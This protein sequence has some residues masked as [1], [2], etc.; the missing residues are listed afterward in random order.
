MTTKTRRCLLHPCHVSSLLCFSRCK[1]RTL[2]NCSPAEICPAERQPCC[3][4]PLLSLSCRA[5]ALQQVSPA[6]PQPSCTSAQAQS[7]LY[8]ASRLLYLSPGT[9]S[10]CHCRS[11]PFPCQSC[12][13]YPKGASPSLPTA[14]AGLRLGDLSLASGRSVTNWVKGNFC[15]TG[16]PLCNVHLCS[17]RQHV[18]CR[19]GEWLRAATTVYPTATWG[20][21]PKPQR[22]CSS[23]EGIRQRPAAQTI[24]WVSIR[25]TTLRDEFSSRDRLH[26]PFPWVEMMLHS[27]VILVTSQT[28]TSQ[29][30]HCFATCRLRDRLLL[31]RFICICW[32]SDW[33]VRRTTHHCPG[34]PPDHI[35]EIVSGG[36]AGHFRLIWA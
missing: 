22:T 12:H 18:V 30:G 35:A 31:V 34:G 9:P 23:N 15:W 10:C 4:S 26:N 1:T 16:L 27:L 5:S 29:T 3:T 7:Q 8:Y 36:N 21:E 13:T 2:L 19:G 20:T 17:K 28:R 24:Q 33:N 14:V 32:G 25:H 6:E 11:L